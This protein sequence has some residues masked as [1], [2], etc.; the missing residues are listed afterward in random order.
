MIGIGPYIREPH[1]PADALW[2]SQFGHL[3]QRAHMQ[4]MLALTTRVNALARVTLGDVNIAATT[5]LQAVHPGGRELALGR[6][7][8]VLM[9]ILTPGRYRADYALYEGKPCI[10]DTAAGC[11]ACLTARVASVGRS[12]AKGAF[13]DPPHARSGG[14]AGVRVRA[15]GSPGGAPGRASYATQAATGHLTPAPPGAPPSQPLRT[16]VAFVGAMN[17]GK[18][19]ALNLLAPGGSIV[20][21]TPGEGRRGGGGEQ[22]WWGDDQTTRESTPCFPPPPPPA[23]T[24]SDVKIAL[25]E[26]HACGPLKLM[27]TAGVDEAGALGAKKRRAA[28]GALAE[29]DVA[30]VVVDVGR[31]GGGNLAHERGL[32]AAAADAGASPL[33]LLNERGGGGGGHP[34]STAVRDALDPHHA[35]PC[36]AVDLAAPHARDAVVAAVQAVI[37]ARA[38]GPAV[39]C[40]PPRYLVPGAAVLLVIPMDAETPEGRLLR[41]QAMVQEEALRAWATTV[42]VRLDLGAARG[43]RGAAAR[44]AERGRFAA[45]VNLVRATAA[46]AGAPCIAVTDSLAVD[47]VH[48][49]TNGAPGD[50]D[51]GD[52]PPP[53][54]DLTTFSIAMINRQ[55]DGALATFVAGTRAAAA[56]RDGDRVVVAEACNHNRILAACADIGGVQVPRAL[57]VVDGGAAI[58]IEHAYGREL[59]EVGGEAG[60]AAAPPPA[61]VVHCGGCMIDRQKVR[62]RLR[63]LASSGVP[64]TNYGLLLAAAAS[65]GAFERVVAPWG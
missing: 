52:A 4:A 55:S 12:V 1:T 10:T 22:W 54:I 44:D 33:L 7:A 58:V 17:S 6:G 38:P 45:V 56:L 8:N 28:L 48:V 40:L 26:L 43:Q 13:G 3:D 53:P 62:A 36:L 64:V 63:A 31:R 47:V 25:A 32:L 50:D 42:A 59:P 57:S 9:P 34:A 5:A 61:L 46:A 29:S 21:D 49:W 30:V 51:G 14:V 23:G 24:T 65:R 35:L 15:P 18:S 41:P 2:A 20:D 39:P 19:T 11:E 60:G 37:A 16:N 27:D